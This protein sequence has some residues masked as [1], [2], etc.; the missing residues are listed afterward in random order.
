MINKQGF[1]K[2]GQWYKGN[3]HSHTTQSD[4]MLTPKE[5]VNLYQE[6]GYHFLCLSDHDKYV[7]YKDKF[8]TE[9][10]I[11]LPG[12][13]CSV[14]LDVNGTRVKVHHIHGILG[15]QELLANCKDPFAVEEKF[16]IKVYKGQWNGLDAAQK[17]VN[18]LRDRGCLVMYN[19]PLWSKVR[20]DEFAELKNVWALEIYNYGCIFEGG[21][22]QDT[23]DWDAILET[24]RQ[25]FGVATDDNHNMPGVNDSCGGWIMVKAEELT[26]ECIV[27]NMRTG[28]FYSSSGPEIYDW[29]IRDGVAYVDCSACK[30]INF[31]CGGA[32]GVGATVLGEK[33]THGEYVLKGMENYVRAECI[34]ENGKTAWSNAIMLTV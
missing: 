12:V 19:H 30:K 4:G 33:V 26:R 25:I 24:G 5:A 10:F 9:D 28:N 1:L 18:E 20:L 23:R 2:E 15:D 22:H 13:E 21:V 17:K 29:G 11:L 3:I 34:D 27:F 7:D 31:V 6:N 16:E 32:V 14:K 8:N